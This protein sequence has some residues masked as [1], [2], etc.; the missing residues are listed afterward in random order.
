M[1]ATALVYTY[2]TQNDIV[3]LMSQE[4]VDLR[5]DDDGSGAVSAAELAYL[6]TQGISYATSRVNW[7]CQGRYDNDQL[8]TSYLVNDWC[9]RLATYWLCTRRGNPAPKS[10]QDLRDEAIEEMKE[11]RN[12][13][14]MIPDLGT[15]NAD[16]PA[17][18]NVRVDPN[19]RLRKIRVERPLSEK[20]PPQDARRNNDWLA[21]AL[22][23]EI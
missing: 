6:T 20:T 8:N 16:W 14:G 18:S 22:Q 4:G 17:W 11:V 12:G 15:R 5:L 21:E 3:A 7:Y 9:T 2:T 13:M 19:Y 10:I 23:Y 1:T